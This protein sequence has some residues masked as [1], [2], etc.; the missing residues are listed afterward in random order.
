[1][2][3][4]ASWVNADEGFSIRPAERADLL[5]IARIE[6]ESFAQPWPYDAFERFLGSPGFLVALEGGAV[7]GYIVADLTDGFGRQLGHVKDI[8][9]H[10]DNR[11]TG[12]GSALLSRAL[13][14]LAARGADSVK[15]EVR[16]S[17][18]RAKRLY[19]Q[20][21]FEA[22]RTVPEYYRDGE[23]AIVMIHK[24]GHCLV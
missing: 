7:A 12:V 22:L 10:P 2:T 8:A 1:M 3:R 4:P 13:A 21:G 23:D 14:V 17:N 18:E 9:V 11:K 20:F 16:R 19:R 5:A 6:N 24:L 15:L